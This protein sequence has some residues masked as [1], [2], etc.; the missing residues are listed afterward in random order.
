MYCSYCGNKIEENT[1]FCPFC[2]K[3]I[4][5]DNIEK[6]TEHLHNSIIRKSI[7]KDAKVKSKKSL[8]I[9]NIIMIVAISIVIFLIKEIYQTFSLD[10]RNMINVIG[11]SL[12]LSIL[13]IIVSTYC[14]LG[15]TKISLD[16]S[17]GNKANISDVL[18]F[19][20]KKPKICLKFLVANIL[21]YLIAM[22]LLSIP[23][24]GT[25]AYCALLIYYTPSL[26]ML[27][28]VMIDDENITIPNAIKK[29]VEIIKGKRV[30]Y[31]ALIFSFI[32]WYILSIPTL[33]L[34]LIWL[35]PYMTVSMSNFYLSITNEK[36]YNSETQGLSNAAIIGITIASYIALIIVAIIATFG[37]AIASG[38]VEETIEDAVQHDDY[39]NYYDNN[40]NNSGDTVNA[41]GLEIFIPAGYQ[42]I[43]IEN[44]EKAYTSNDKKIVIGLL[45]YDI[46][47]EVSA[48]D[49]TTL[50]KE[51]LSKSYTCGNINTS[52]INNDYWEVLDCGET[53][54]N[55][56]NYITKEND[57]IYL[58]AISYTT[59][60]TKDAKI[61]INNIEKKLAFTNIVA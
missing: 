41:L 50:Y 56:R 19:S 30:A 55:I 38:I 4:K 34:L 42:E 33:G 27:A 52:T 29:T 8:Y 60:K 51:A 61:L 9:A 58:L 23:V 54:G 47:N 40:K 13:I 39:I 2:G 37:F 15:I 53:T 25:I 17:R 16:I 5:K 35:I 22:L 20:I 28:Y 31:Y 32:G 44:Y 18:K 48:R 24:I 45:T 49:Y 46:P 6:E 36:K 21:I 11:F 1:N 57:K 3:E 14:M 12:F 26:S 59:D 7:K 43:T 10:Y